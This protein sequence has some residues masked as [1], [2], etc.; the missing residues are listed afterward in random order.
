MPELNNLTIPRAKMR[1]LMDDVYN[2]FY[3]KWRDDMPD[4]PDDEYSGVCLDAGRIME[5]YVQF[6]IAAHLVISFMYELA[7]LHRGKYTKIEKRKLLEIVKAWDYDEEA[8]E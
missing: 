2:G 3:R 4:L 1:E 5:R 6:P 7:A 8:K